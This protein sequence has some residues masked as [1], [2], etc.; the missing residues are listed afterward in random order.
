VTTSD[1]IKAITAAFPG[2][3]VTVWYDGT[4]F[5]A[6]FEGREKNDAMTSECRETPGDAVERFHEKLV[7]RAVKGHGIALTHLHLLT[8]AAPS[9]SEAK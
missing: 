4:H 1:R 9:E 3:A 8:G 6:G 2:H 5:R 7:D